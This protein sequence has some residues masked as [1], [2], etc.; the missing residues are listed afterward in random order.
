MISL[1]VAMGTNR[2]IGR[3]GRLPWRMPGDMK[4]FREVTMGKAIIMGRVTYESIGRPLDGRHNIV[5]TRDRDYPAQGCTIVNSIE[6]ALDAAGKGEVM[7]IGG[8]LLYEQLL[9]KADRIYL[10]LIDAEFVGDSYFP[11]IS[12][13]YWSQVSLEICSADDRN[14]HN[15]AFMVLE[16]TTAVS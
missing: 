12:A 3:D 8:A 5:V 2:V 16:R 11:E 9:P 7:I 1:V 13:A 6:E 15:Y 10:T 4:R 14:P